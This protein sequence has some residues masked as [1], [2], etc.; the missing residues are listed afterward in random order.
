MSILVAHRI[1]LTKH[2]EPK[3]LK[4]MVRWLNDPDV[5]QFSEQRHHR[6]DE[7]SQAHYITDGCSIFREI[8]TEKRFIGTITADIDRANSVANVGILIGEKKEWGKGYGTE[9]WKTF[10]DHLLT[11]GIRKIEAGTMACNYGMLN[12]FR[13]TGMH[14]EGQRYNHFL[15]GN[16]LFDLLQWARFA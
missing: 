7:E 9:A 16:E 11:H 1:L 12:I 14:H 10:C 8:H 4:T 13:R 6:H 15:L 2:T 3:H 5:V